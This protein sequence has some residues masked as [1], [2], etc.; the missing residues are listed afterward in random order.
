[1]IVFLCKILLLKRIWK[2]VYGKK[3]S[4][5]VIKDTLLVFL[6]FIYWVFFMENKFLI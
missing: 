1:M 4:M 3:C 6:C 5:E 2:K